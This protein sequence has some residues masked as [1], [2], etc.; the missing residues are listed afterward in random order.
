MTL[1]GNESDEAR[2]C[3][4]A[5][6]KEKDMTAIHLENQPIRGVSVEDEEFIASFSEEAKKKTI[7]KVSSMQWPFRWFSLTDESQVDV[8][9]LILPCSTTNYHILRIYAAA[10]CSYVC[11]LILGGIYRQDK[12]RYIHHQHPE[13]E[14]LEELT[15]WLGNAKIEGL[16][17]SLHMDGIQYNIA[18]SI[19]FIPYVLAGNIHFLPITSEK[20]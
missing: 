12:Y 15:Q 9:P 7:R 3:R 10:T 11:S 18:L 4:N 13:R 1:T 17:P 6:E 8:R 16:L 19:F 20:G 2:H 5:P 14:T